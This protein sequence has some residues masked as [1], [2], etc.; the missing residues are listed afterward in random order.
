QKAVEE[1]LKDVHTA[2]Q[3]PLP[4][5]VI[6]EPESGKFQPL[7]EVHGK[8]KEKVSEEQAAQVILNLQTPNKKSFVDQF[9]FQ[10]RTPAQT[11]PSGHE[12]SSSLYVEL[13]LTDNEMEFDD[14]VSSKINPKAQD[15]G[16]TGPNPG[17][18]VEGQARSNPG[19][20]AESQPQSSHVVVLKE[21]ASSTGTLSFLQHLAKDFSFGDQ[22]FNDKPFDVE[23]EKTTA[24]TKAESM[25][26]VTIHQ[27]TSAIPP[28]TS[29]V[30]D[31]ISRPDSPNEHRPL[32]PIAT[33][34]ATTTTSIT[35]LPL[36]PQP[37]QSTIDSILIKR[38]ENLD[39]PHQESK[40]VDEI[41]TDAV[42]WAIQALL[43]D[44]FRDL[45]EADMKE[46]LHHRMWETNSYKT[47]EDHKKLKKKKR[48]DLPKTPPGSPPHQPPPPPP[49]A[50][51]S[52]TS[53]ASE[54][55][56]LSQLPLP[57]PPLST[58]QSDQLKPSVSSIPEDLHM[59]ADSAPYE[60]VHSSDIEDIRNDHIPKVNLNQDWW[61]PLP[62]EDIPAT[63]EP[64]W[65]IPSFDMPFL[66]NN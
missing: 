45:P 44:R 37:Q 18:H 13:G 62:E 8:G 51:P 6:R 63:P 26:S 28:M 25:V 4:P 2:H 61:K 11:K 46:I 41:V 29:L 40:A 30:I 9:I 64:A 10:R 55:S 66:M 1:S 7:P 24:E 58:N 38:I 22:F 49:P 33:T 34:T 32:P 35:T 47:H 20:D 16:Q 17:K 65:S 5:V 48:H 12:E 56:G 23:N 19:D 50:G 14:D 39:I 53:G 57:P 42:D 27:D 15:E 43:R 60:Q 21:I 52:G 59:D 36:P 31:L 3:G 54:T